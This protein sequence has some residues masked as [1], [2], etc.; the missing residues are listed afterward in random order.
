MPCLECRDGKW[1]E[2]KLVDEHNKPYANVP[3]KLIGSQGQTFEGTTS[4]S[5][6]IFHQDVVDTHFSF[7]VKGIELLD[8]QRSIYAE[9]MQPPEIW[10]GDNTNKNEDTWQYIAHEYS[11]L[12][13]S[14]LSNG[15][16]NNDDK[17]SI[18]VSVDNLAALNSYVVR[19]KTVEVPINII[20]LVPGT[21]DPVNMSPLAKKHNYDA[22]TTYWETNPILIKQLTDIKNE[23]INCE[24]NYE[25]YSWSGDNRAEARGTS[26]KLGAQALAEGA[27]LRLKNLLYARPNKPFYEGWLDRPLNFHLIGHSHG[28]NVINEFTQAIKNDFPEKW[29][30]KSLTYLSTP[31]FKTM[32]PIDS[33]QFHPDATLINVYNQYDITQHT[34]ANFTVVSLH[35]IHDILPLLQRYIDELIELF[36][37]SLDKFYNFGSGLALFYDSDS[38]AARWSALGDELLSL[39]EHIAEKYKR[40]SESLILY[41]D[42]IPES[43][44]S[45]FFQVIT[46][47]KLWAQKANRLLKLRVTQYQNAGSVKRALVDY[48]NPSAFYDAVSITGLINI[49]SELLG[50]NLANS[51]LFNVIDD[52]TV[53][54]VSV[55]DDTKLR[56]HQMPAAINNNEE[57]DVTEKDPYHD[58]GK[59]VYPDFLSKMAVNQASYQSAYDSG[60]VKQQNKLRKEFILLLLAQMDY[61]KLVKIRNQLNLSEWVTFGGLDTSITKL[62]KN[63]DWM[64]NELNSRHFPLQV[65]DDLLLHYAIIYQQQRAEKGKDKQNDYRI[66]QFEDWLEAHVLV[67]QQRIITTLKQY[68]VTTVKQLIKSIKATHPQHQYIMDGKSKLLKQESIRGSVAYLA[69]TSHSISRQQLYSAEPNIEEAFIACL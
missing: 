7:E 15:N 20:L 31:F 61:S 13:I 43:L 44:F 57:F 60:N 27:G 1:I 40:L 17:E 35:Q 51:T 12:E 55:F 28:G 23:H 30:I 25:F 5:G 26:S 10:A 68:R 19:P 2:L 49:A 33:S 4:S 24:L 41:S 37:T 56:P 52:I 54:I 22:D 46:Q 63:L 48:F 11:D 58:Y 36:S 16:Q 62:R 39:N 67:E 45:L 14:V 3:Y 69:I 42:V 38:S 66:K 64:L 59:E 9:L 34:I 47:Y 65:A 50:E 29:N 18:I 8:I 6:Y 32:H 21:T 53:K